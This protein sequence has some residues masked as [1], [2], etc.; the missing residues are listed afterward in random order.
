MVTL[1]PK[2]M[3]LGNLRFRGKNANYAMTLAIFHGPLYHIGK[4]G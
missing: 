2:E 3:A 1:S 4:R